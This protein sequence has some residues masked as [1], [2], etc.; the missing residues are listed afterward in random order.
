MIII[1]RKIKNVAKV[2]IIAFKREFTA[3]L[4]N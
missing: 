3:F 2:D 4:I 1:N